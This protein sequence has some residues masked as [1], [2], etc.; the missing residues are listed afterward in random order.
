MS[1]VV[2]V[3]NGGADLKKCLQSIAA[4]SWRSIECVVVDDASDDGMTGIAADSIGARVIWLKNQRGP[5]RARNRGVEEATGDIIFF[6]DADVV[7]HEDTIEKAV[8]VLQNSP[9]TAAVFG[10]YDTSP[11]NASFISQ[12]RN[13]YHHWIHQTART[14]ASTFWTGCGAI[15]RSVFI[16]AGGFNES[17]DRP[18]I[19]DIEFGG[20]LLASGHKIR[21]EKEMQCQHLKQWTLGNVIYTDVFQRGIPWM[22]LLLTSHELPNDLNISYKSRIAT[23]LAGLLA[24]AVVLLPLTGHA[25]TLIPSVFFLA[26]SASCVAMAF[27]PRTPS[28]LP[29]LL[30]ILPASFALIYDLQPLS[31]LPLAMILIIAWTQLGF[32]VLVAKR[33][34]LAFAFAVVPMQVIFFAGCAFSAAMGIMIHFF[35]KFRE[36]FA[37]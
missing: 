29:L 13:L 8:R 16:D 11:E 10:S 37:R 17:F 12:Y 9:E 33:H 26:A 1:I 35:G 28:F 7:V 32:Y 24:L 25:D 14:D 4:S 21:L 15:R 27:K 30:V 19:E 18:S 34:N 31:V 20:R 2:P 22:K 5:S 23:L 6:V 36:L 3:Y